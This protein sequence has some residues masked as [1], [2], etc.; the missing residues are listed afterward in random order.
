MYKFFVF[1]V[2]FL[3]NIQFL[4]CQAPDC[5]VAINICQNASFQVNPNGSGQ[6]QELLNNN[7]SNP[8]SNPGGS[9][10]SGCLLSGELNP[11]WMIINIASTGTLQFSLGQDMGTGCFD[12]IMWPYT[13]NTCNQIISN[14]LAPIRCNWNGMCEGFTGMASPLPPGGDP[15][16]FEIP[17]NVTAGQ[18]YILCMSNYSSQ[19][20][21]VPLNFF[22]SANVSCNSVSP[23]TVN[24]T[25]ICPGQSV[26]LTA[27]YSGNLSN[28]TWSPG[29]QTGTSITVSPTS[30]TTYSVSA[31]GTNSNGGAVTGAGSATI[32]VLSAND[33]T[34]GCI[35]NASNSGPVCVGST[36]NLSSTILNGTYDWVLNGTSIGTTQNI[37][38][39]PATTPGNFTFNLTGN[40]A[41]GHTCT[42]STTV[43][44]NPLPIVNAGIDVTAC[45]NTP[46]TFSA[47]G[48]ATY[49][50]SNNVQNGIAFTPTIAGIY[51]VIGTDAN[52]CQ[53]TDD[54]QLSFINASPPLITPSV[55]L[56]CSPLYVTFQ[57][58]SGTD[59]NCVWDF[60]NGTVSN[61]C[62]NQNTIY[63]QTGCY[64]VTLSHTDNQGCDTTVTFQNI[65]CVEESNASFSFT[66]GM[67]GPGNNTTSFLNTSS[68]AT[69]YIW[70]FGDGDSS[71][72]FEPI[73]EFDITP[74]IGYEITLI[75][76]SPAGCPDTAHL[77]VEYEEQLI[78]YV[79]NS[80]TPDADEHNQMFSPV[81]TSGFDPYNF[82]MRIYNR[83][84]ELIFETQ[85]HTKGW[86]GSYGKNGGRVQSGVYTWVIKFKPKNNDDKITVN[87]FVNVLK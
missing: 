35:I 18:Q 82:E 22:G 83:W 57:N 8:T 5:N 26:T 24:S 48:A 79:P 27:T 77:A 30:T 65:I 59:Q 19:T 13:S 29:G 32:T 51:N 36:F 56:G 76:F 58:N 46:V 81:F 86:D 55:T 11:T 64:D 31:S 38:N 80:F 10:N 15:S 72:L 50:W 45:R 69:S 67:I 87:G 16:N 53:D 12:W 74:Q 52:G 63:T 62:S 28:F 84:G 6:V 2:F 3:L 75:S 41:A 37:L 17:L 49:S 25:S 44:V 40:D 21:N 1:H 14:Q 60:G 4:L 9:G 43:I 47:S 68:G 7:I 73:H 70:Y 20:T 23:I 61:D 39:V 85:D 78:F 34:C 42:S 54:L 71:N 33:P 66:P